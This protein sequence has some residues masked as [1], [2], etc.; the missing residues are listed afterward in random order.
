M[1][2]HIV[3]LNGSP[4]LHGNTA[5]LCDAFAEG[6]AEA[7]H[8]VT[9]FDLQRMDIRGCLGCVKGGKDA[10]HPCVQWDDMAAIYPAYTAAATRVW[11]EALDS[12]LRDPV[13]Y[14]VLPQWTEA[15]SRLSE[16]QQQTLGA[17][18][19]SWK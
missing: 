15:L 13:A 2:K 6:A 12:C 3:I 4:R 16:G 14:R 8:T 19:R 9:R 17:Y 5:L 11:R 18:Y 1:S 10:A 7:G